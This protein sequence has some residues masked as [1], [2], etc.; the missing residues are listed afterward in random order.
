MAPLLRAG[1]EP[2]GPGG[3]AAGLPGG[4][5]DGTLELALRRWREAEVGAERAG[6]T[7]PLVGRPDTEVLVRLAAEL[8]APLRLEDWPSPTQPRPVAGDGWIHD[9]VLDD[10]RE[11]FEAVLAA[12]A[13]DGAESVAAACQE[14]RFPVT[15]YR[16]PG[17]P[18]PA[19]DRGRERP[20][21]VP[22]GGT[23]PARERP[24][25]VIDLSTHWAGPLAT[26]LLAEAGAEV[27][28]VDPHCRPDGFRGRPRLYRHLN[29]AKEIVDLD[30]RRPD[31]RRRFEALV[32]GADLLVESFSRRVLA[33]LGY[34]RAAL[35]E[36]DPGLAV[37]SIKAFPAGTAEADW[38]AYGPGVHAAS[39]LGLASGRPVPAPVAYP[40]LVAGVTAYA[41]AVDLLAD[42]PGGGQEAGAEISLAGSI[43]A[44]VRA[45][46]DDGGAGD[47]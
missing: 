21:P 10:D 45:A 44:L 13:G 40:D 7:P 17:G 22:G 3:P 20:Q 34:D 33:N 12:R 4:V 29:E 1:P 8:T 9:E 24:V 23:R 14:L 26:A 2:V 27:V 47:G 46:A 15:P 32:T 19:P 39:G 35:A 28:K 25:R 38:L 42:P 36:L 43:S 31:D 37:V 11:A 5:P 30:L 16:W 6:L 18:V 41:M